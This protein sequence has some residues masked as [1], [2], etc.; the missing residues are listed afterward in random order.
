MTGPVTCPAPSVVRVALA[1]DEPLVRTG[2]RTILEASGRVSV[3]LEAGNGQELLDRLA[4]LGPQ[5]APD[6][7]VTDLRMPVRD[8]VDVLVA[9]AAR[10][11]GLPC[12]VLTTFAEVDLVDRAVDAG[13]VGYLLKTASPTELVQGVLAAASGGACFSPKVAARLL[14]RARR[15]VP[16]GHGPTPSA[17]RDTV[18]TLPPR[19]APVLLLVTRGLGNAEIA[20]TLHLSEHT[21]KGYVSDLLDGLGVA[22]RVGAAMVGFRAGLLDR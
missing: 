12:V 19:L 16:S 3:V 17:A 20:R 2:I 11:P 6:V 13:A 10:N 8:G 15:P 14:E 22:N 1:D 7:V 5:Q 9:T 18:G 21:V 4:G